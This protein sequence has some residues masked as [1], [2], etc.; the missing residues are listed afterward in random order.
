MS[1]VKFNTFGANVSATDDLIARMTTF[2]AGQAPDEAA[3]VRDVASFRAFLNSLTVDDSFGTDQPTAQWILNGRKWKP[4]A[5]GRRSEDV[6]VFDPHPIRSV[7][8]GQPTYTYYQVPGTDGQ[9]GR[10]GYGRVVLY[11]W[12]GQGPPPVYQNFVVKIS[13]DPFEEEGFDL[14]NDSNA[15]KEIVCARILKKID[16]DDDQ[17]SLYRPPPGTSDHARN[18]GYLFRGSN[19]RYFTA[20]EKADGTL[21]SLL[22][23][24]PGSGDPLTAFRIVYGMFQDIKNIYDSSRRG[25][26]ERLVV[27]GKKGIV[28][29]DIKLDNFLFL[30]AV[31]RIRTVR[32]NKDYHSKKYMRLFPCDFGSFTKEWDVN[33]P[34][35]LCS[36]ELRSPADDF[37]HVGIATEGYPEEDRTPDGEKIDKTGGNYASVG[38]VA[39]CLGV[40]MLQLMDGSLASDDDFCFYRR[41]PNDASEVR[42][43]TNP[44]DSNSPRH[45]ITDEQIICY[46]RWTKYVEFTLN[47]MSLADYGRGGAARDIAFPDR[48]PLFDSRI[49][50]KLLNFTHHD[51]MVDGKPHP[52]NWS[53]PAPATSTATEFASSVQANWNEFEKALEVYVQANPTNIRNA[54][55]A[56]IQ[57]IDQ[58]WA[59][60]KCALAHNKPEDLT[61]GIYRFCPPAYN[62]FITSYDEMDYEFTRAFEKLKKAAPYKELSK[63]AA[64]DAGFSEL[65]PYPEYA[66]LKRQSLM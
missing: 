56:A 14:L 43:L 1:V 62:N 61:M 38:H 33:Q 45:P 29:S 49:L 23:V 17:Y 48:F 24:P 7:S 20:M 60:G 2:N 9:I 46:I 10:G 31:Q 32:N 12:D 52:L 8:A 26:D 27:R 39:F 36:T 66:T 57:R 58:T 54:C 64:Q 41:L 6:A 13:A 44:E 21:T 40:T 18:M 42:P 59:R 4:V 65:P 34:P 28:M 16:T 5:R 47:T 22:P 50:R 30:N 53:I 51:R 55:L 15:D 35:T 25:P 19:F 63:N 3:E 37:L 11:A